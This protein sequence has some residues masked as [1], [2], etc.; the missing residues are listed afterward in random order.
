MLLAAATLLATATA[1]AD[2]G[3]PLLTAAGRWKAVNDP[4]MGGI[5][6]SG[7]KLGGNG[8]GVWSGEVKVVPKLH[9]P[10]FCRVNGELP[11][12][13]DDRTLPDHEPTRLLVYRDDKHLPRYLALT[14]FA[15]ALMQ[16]LLGEG[17]AVADGLRAACEGL[18]VPLDDERL[19]SAAQL[20]ADLGE[21]GVCLGTEPE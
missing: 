21:R 11:K 16:Q 8:V 20:F 17:K 6:N 1:T 7:F 18:G 12:A 19:A 14:P 13:V 10:G 5:S 4:V 9:A 15:F 3:M 2:A